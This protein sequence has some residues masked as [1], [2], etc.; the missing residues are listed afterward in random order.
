MPGE[1]MTTIETEAPAKDV[2]AKETKPT[3][4]KKTT[5][6]RKAAAKKGP[7]KKSKKVKNSNIIKDVSYAYI[8]TIAKSLDA[9][10]ELYGKIKN[11]RD[12]VYKELIKSGET[13][14]EKYE[15]KLRE[16]SDHLKDSLSLKHQKKTSKQAASA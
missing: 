4:A 12:G 7:S 13:F 10:D 15:K 14:T 8:G 3:V 1:I 9:V 6:Q 11:D 16:K 5:T 2:P